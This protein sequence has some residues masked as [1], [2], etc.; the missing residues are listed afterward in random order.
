MEL[1]EYFLIIKK[2]FKL[3]LTISGLILA[4][5][6]A[7]LFFRPISFDISLTLNITRSGAQVSQNYQYDDFYRLQADEKF[8]ETVVE[9][10]KSPKIEEDIYANSGVDTEGFDLKK[11]ASSI[12]A[13]KRSA[14]I[15]A[16]SFSAPDQKMA[17]SIALSVSKVIS[18]NIQNLN[19][20]QKEATWFEV[21]PND[22]VIRLHKIN[23]LAVAILFVVAIFL[24]FF[25]VL[26]KHYLE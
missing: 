21:V 11:L 14:Q 17:K 12:L 6:L 20:N 8:A 16:V 4:G 3:F 7:Y 18:Q 2:Q 19:Q 5:G 10:L 13:E 22:P 24:A 1:K 15:V 25:G 9:W 26:F 23:P